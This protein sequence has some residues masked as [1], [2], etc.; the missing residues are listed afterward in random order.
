MILHQ[1]ENNTL[2]IPKSYES[3]GAWKAPI[4]FE[5]P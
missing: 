2:M 1:G 4:V 5:I 3:L